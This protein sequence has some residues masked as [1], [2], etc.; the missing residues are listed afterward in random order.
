MKNK[1][2]ISA[3]AILFA[4]GAAWAQ[5]PRNGNGPRSGYNDGRMMDPVERMSL[6]LDLNENQRDKI[7]S[8]HLSYAQKNQPIRNEINELEAKLQ[9]LTSTNS[10]NRNEVN[11]TVEQIGDLRSELYQNR[12]ACQLDIR[13]E[14]DEGQKL[15]YDQFKSQ[16][17]GRMQGRRCR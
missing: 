7:E 9:T 13:A 6:R 17:R 10:P 2:I 4:C 15:R 12:T 5:G 14:L 1:L 8:I 16:G 11:S 3:L